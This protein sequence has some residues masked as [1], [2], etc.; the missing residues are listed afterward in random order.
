[1]SSDNGIY[2]AKF[3]DGYRVIHDQAIDNI[4][5]HRPNTKVRK[6]VIKNYFKDS[7]VFKTKK[8]AIKK[9]LK[10]EEEI[11]YTE[12]GIC[13]LGELENFE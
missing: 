13:D 6:N 8:S 1:M 7:K 12:Y 4:F 2:L 3:S 9:A 5:Y 10:L 11:G